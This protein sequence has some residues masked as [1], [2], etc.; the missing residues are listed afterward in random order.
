MAYWRDVDAR[1]FA[2]QPDVKRYVRRHIQC[3]VTG[4]QP[5]GPNLGG[6]D[7]IVELWFDDIHR[8]NAF[9]NSP[10]YFNVSKLDEERFTDPKKCGYFFGRTYHHNMSINVCR[11]WIISVPRRAGF[12]I[13]L[14]T[15]RWQRHPW[16]G[17][18]K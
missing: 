1:L 2:S 14:T 17:E 15:M 10:S 5:T 13:A 7:G 11:R 8:F 12:L 18:L 4:D 16:R 9:A 6:T 3:H